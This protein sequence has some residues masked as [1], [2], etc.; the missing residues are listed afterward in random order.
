MMRRCP[1]CRSPYLDIDEDGIL[2]CTDCETDEDLWYD[3]FGPNWFL[4]YV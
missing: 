2:W 1:N 4:D 3:W